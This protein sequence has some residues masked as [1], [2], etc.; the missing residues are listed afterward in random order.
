MVVAVRQVVEPDV[1]DDYPRVSYGPGDRLL[2]QGVVEAQCRLGDEE[3]TG[4]Q[5]LKTRGQHVALPPE[6][7]PNK[8]SEFLLLY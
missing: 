1:E 3:A 6:P 5:K 8:N 7:V 4:R 2:R